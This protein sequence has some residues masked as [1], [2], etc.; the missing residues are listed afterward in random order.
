MWPIIGVVLKQTDIAE[1]R[2]YAICSIIPLAQ[3]Y[4]VAQTAASYR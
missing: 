1:V 2:C 3:A 4:G